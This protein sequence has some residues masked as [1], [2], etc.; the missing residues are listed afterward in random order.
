MVQRSTSVTLILRWL[1][2]VGSGV[3][4]ICK[5]GEVRMWCAICLE[6]I[7]FGNTHMPCTKGESYR[8]NLWPLRRG[9]RPDSQVP[10][11]Q[12]TLPLPSSTSIRRLAMISE[13]ALIC[14]I[15]PH[16]PWYDP[17]CNKSLPQHNHEGILQFHM[18]KYYEIIVILF[19]RS[20]RNKQ[21]FILG[22]IAQ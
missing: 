14:I 9:E 18:C 19:Q 17:Q 1:F 6:L 22:T 7:W 3:G 2:G 13:R 8:I 16:S 20:G 10:R 15:H 12:T 4:S 5:G 21:G 11:H